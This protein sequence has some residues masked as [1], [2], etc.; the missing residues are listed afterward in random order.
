LRPSKLDKKGVGVFAIKRIPKG[1]RIFADENEELCWISKSSLPKRGPMRELYDAFAV[2]EANRY[3]CPTSFNRL[4]PAWFLNESKN[5]NTRSDENYD[6]HSLRDIV[7]G[8]ELTVD[9]STFSRYP[10]KPGKH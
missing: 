6:F 8:E 2:I 5:P 4:T 3:G 7:A 10:G 9:Y 1:T